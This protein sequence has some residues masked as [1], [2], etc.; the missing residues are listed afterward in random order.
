MPS[1]VHSI[2]AVG[3][4]FV[5]MAAVVMLAEQLIGLVLRQGGRSAGS[6]PG[7][8]YLAMNLTAATAAA[9]AGGAAAARLAPAAPVAHAMALALLVLVMGIASAALAGG[10]QPR[11]YQAVLALV[12]P[13]IV[14]AGG[15]AAFVWG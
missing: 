2:A 6:G 8:A 9:L 12:M 3:A 13:A 7:R 1:T 14:I 11:W 4:S 15:W 10:S 5:L